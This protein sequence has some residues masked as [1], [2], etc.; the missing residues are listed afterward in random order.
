MRPYYNDPY[1]VEFDAD[2]IEVSK[3]ENN[4][5]VYLS[6]S[7]F[8]PTSGGQEHD[9]GL[10]GDNAVIDVFEE[11]GRIVHVVSGEAAKGKVHCSI[12]WTRRFGNMQQH[13]G[14]HILSA[15]FENLFGIET[16]SSRLGEY[17]GTIDLSRQPAV[18]EIERVVEEANKIVRENR[19][20]TVRYADKENIGAL[21]L[22]K[23]PKVDGTVRIIEIKD[24]DMSPCGGTHCTHASEVGII[25][26][27][28]I[29][30]VKNALTRIEF[31]CGTRGVRHYYELLKSAHDA[32]RLLSTSSVDLPSAV[33]KMKSQMQEKEDRIRFLSGKMLEE[34]CDK[35]ASGLEH[36]NSALQV[37]DLSGEVQTTDELRFVASCVSRK[38]KSPFAFHRTEGNICYMNLNLT[39]DEKV[40]SA[41]LGE[42]RNKYGVKGGGR[43]GFFS[44]AF[45]RD[46]I[47]EV[48]TLISRSLT[49][50]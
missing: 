7:F 22:R 48:V 29:E 12:D 13:T 14:Q 15:A 20:V 38:K 4:S 49:G 19:P 33:E 21:N 32:S 18:E 26:T 40:T 2:I 28:N 16:V 10:I 46:L 43:N 35:L 8:Y 44:V 31:Y 36:P 30:K 1:T 27:G 17:T 9:T 25:L 6:D 5:A 41:I 50:E 37:V 11:N 39:S 24:F 23:P 47:D 34:V 3:R 45:D 42:L